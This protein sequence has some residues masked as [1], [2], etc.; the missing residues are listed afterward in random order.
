[1]KT[2]LI[3]NYDSF[4][5]NLY[6]LLGEVNGEAP[7]VIRNDEVDWAD[8]S[9]AGFDNIVISPGP[10]RPDRP[11]DF[12]I[13]ARAILESPL[14]V[15][16]VC[17]GHQ[18]ICHLFGG[19]VDLAPQPMHGRLAKVYHTGQHMFTGI[20]SPFNVVRYHSLAATQLPDVLEPLAWTADDVLM[21]VR[22]RS[23]PI[24]GVQFH[25]ESICTEHGHRLIE[26][27]RALTEQYVGKKASS[28][29][30]GSVP[31]LEPR[32]S[33]VTAHS[34]T[35]IL[36]T[37]KLPFLPDAERA[38]TTLFAAAR[39][40]FWLDSS[41]VTPN[42]SRFSFM[43]N[44][45]GPHAEFVSYSVGDKLVMVERS[46]E[47]ICHHGQFFDY[48]NEEL[49]NRFIPAT[50]LPFEFNLGYVGYLGYELKAE[51]GAK[52]VHPSPTPDAAM[53]FADRMLVLD[54]DEKVSY[55]LCLS[56]NAADAA[57]TRWLDDMTRSLFELHNDP[58]PKDASAIPRPSGLHGSCPIEFRHSHETYLDLIA[59]CQKEIRNGES[60]EICLTNMLSA[61]GSIDPVRTYSYLRRISPGPYA[62]LLKFPDLAVLSSSPERFLT[63]TT[64]GIVETKPIKGTRPRGATPEEDEALRLDLE[65]NE[66][67]RSENLMIVD[68]LRNDLNS[69]CEIGS[70]HVPRLFG[71]ESY[72]TVHQL[73]STIRGS[74]RPG[75]SAVDCVRAAFPGGSMTGAP[76]IRTMEIIDRLEGGSRGVYSGALGYFALNGA[77]DFNIIIR[78]IIATPGNLSFGVGGA[79]VAL[80]DSESEFQETLVKA[81]AVMAAIAATAT[82]VRLG[83]DPQPESAP[84]V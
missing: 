7:V 65:Q 20:P 43:G 81:R 41:A 50:G 30:G 59:E 62:A 1:M 55:L 10:G 79:I 15:L 39:H 25:P 35:Y 57:A 4:T 58:L 56:K 63:I 75:F 34:G 49:R 17:L 16:G 71:I 9:L 80:S 66:K 22:H 11:S 70:V 27:F 72:A 24:W 48:L 68:L 47:K 3:D 29:S 2:L 21:A 8:L 38:Y 60:Y 28:V 73:V 31:A 76:K 45:S 40:S 82:P 5:Y 33:P 13:S 78:T 77:A 64:D 83:A 67:D 74:L 36:Q 61:K 18:G 46:G 84:I 53:V 54:H 12:G 37:R 23:R 42:L 44:D 52:A 26:N 51:C 6:Q 32:R 69:T 19:H 14:P